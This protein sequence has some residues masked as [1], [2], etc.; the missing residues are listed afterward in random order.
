MHSKS[1]PF[2][3]LIRI[4]DLEERAERDLEYAIAYIPEG[5]ID[6]NYLKTTSLKSREQT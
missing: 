6:L 1:R 3:K 4:N 2:L 5:S